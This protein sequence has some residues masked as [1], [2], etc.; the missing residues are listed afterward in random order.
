M[1]RN[2]GYVREGEGKEKKERKKIRRN[3]VLHVSLERKGG[4]N[5][6]MP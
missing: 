2:N 4:N 6:L 5:G 1:G 3:G